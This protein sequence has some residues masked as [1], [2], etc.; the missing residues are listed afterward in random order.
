MAGAGEQRMPD[1]TQGTAA[2]LLLWIIVASLAVLTPPLYYYSPHYLPA[3][4]E[5]LGLNQFIL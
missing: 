3:A 5:F 2:M 4:A 1:Q